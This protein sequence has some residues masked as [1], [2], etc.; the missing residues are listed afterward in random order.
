MSVRKIQTL[1]IALLFAGVATL[2][3]GS[4]AS[5]SVITPAWATG[6]TDAANL[7]ASFF[8]GY[9][10]VTTEDFS[11][12]GTNDQ[13]PLNLAVGTLTGGGYVGDNTTPQFGTGEF[14]VGSD[15]NYWSDGTPGSTDGKSTFT[16]SF[17][18][19]VAAF[20][21]Y[22]TD[23]QDIGG[24]VL[25]TF[26]T[27]GGDVTLNLFD[28][29]GAQASGTLNYFAFS[30]DSAISSVTFHA[31]GNDGY[32]VDNISTATPIPG[33]VWLLGSGLLSL[34]GLRRRNRS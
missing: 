30:S 5:A 18:T 1:A 25:L 24:E 34:V 19:P 11:S 29:V 7:E 15:L 21:F 32:A 28:L 22:A 33:A 9:S 20:G 23:L 31:S 26:S 4:A 6:A 8:G 10:N 12:F 13:G 3:L 14:S 2:G 17:T 27:A 16:L